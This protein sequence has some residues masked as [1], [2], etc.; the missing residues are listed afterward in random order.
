MK[1]LVFLRAQRSGVTGWM[2]TLTMLS[3]LILPYVVFLALWAFSD[4]HAMS[5]SEEQQ[6]HNVTPEEA[7]YSDSPWYRNQFSRPFKMLQRIATL[8]LAMSAGALGAGISIAHRARNKKDDILPNALEV[9]STVALG[10]VS[11]LI[12]TCLFAAGILNGL[13]FPG[14]RT[15]VDWFAGLLDSYEETGKL[16]LWSLAAGFSERVIPGYLAEFA[17]KLEKAKKSLGGSSDSN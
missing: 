8:S 13:F 15:A 10:T 2:V 3:V 11:A 9:A 12:L 14:G 16:A 1:I 4:R 5:P 6:I 17:R 7:Y